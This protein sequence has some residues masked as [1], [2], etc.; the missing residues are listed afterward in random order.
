MA[1]TDNATRCSPL[2]LAVSGPAKRRSRLAK[3][4]QLLER[5][6]ELVSEPPV[7]FVELPKQSG[8]GH[9]K[10]SAYRVLPA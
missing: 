10:G 9:A 5:V 8:H 4:S 7:R 3:C 6:P 2:C 1:L